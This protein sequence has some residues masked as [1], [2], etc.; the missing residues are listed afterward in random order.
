MSAGS[1][2]GERV[3]PETPR[4]VDD[5]L[6]AEGTR[7]ERA[8]ASVEAKERQRYDTV[9]Y[10]VRSRQRQKEKEEWKRGEKK[11]KKRRGGCQGLA[12]NL[13]S[14]ATSRGSGDDIERVDEAAVL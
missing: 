4:H 1:S 9:E 14:G 5:S 2:P 13:F 3:L 11:K 8:V 10:K 6:L 7:A 12:Q